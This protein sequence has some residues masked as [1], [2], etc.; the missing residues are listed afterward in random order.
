MVR[1]KFK[2]TIRHVKCYNTPMGTPTYSLQQL[3]EL[4]GIEPRTIRWYISEGLIRGPE[5]LGRGA[6]Y[7]EHHLKR[8]NTIKVLKD[9]YGMQLTEIR[10]Y[11]TMAGD[12]DIQVVPVWPSGTPSPKPPEQVEVGAIGMSPIDARF[13]W[14][15][16]PSRIEKFTDQLEEHQARDQA[17][18][19]RGYSSGAPISMLLSSLRKLLGERRIPRTARAE[20]V[21]EIQINRDVGLRVRGDYEEEEIVLFEQLADHLRELLL[22]SEER[23]KP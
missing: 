7:T 18:L 17:G 15:R 4:T 9:T 13:G 1:F 10:R 16:P 19:R 11:I 3:A 12:E 2:L 5:S 21:T 14:R 20:T 6:H 8:L 22:G 23:G